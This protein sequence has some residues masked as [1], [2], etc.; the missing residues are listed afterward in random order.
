MTEVNTVL[1]EVEQ[2]R[3]RVRTRAH[4]GAWVP[5]LAIGTFLVCSSLLY[6]QPF[7]RWLVKE[8]QFPYWAGLPDEQRSPVVSYL[9]WFL[10]LPLLVGLIGWWYRW[11]SR[12][13]GIRVAW[14][15]FAIVAIGS[16]VLLGLLSSVPASTI[17]VGSATATVRLNRDLDWLSAFATP[18][19]AM[20]L[21]VVVL[22][23]VER[24]GWLIFAG[25]WIGW[26]TWWQGAF[27]TYGGLGGLPPW[28]GGPGVVTL[29]GV[30]RPGWLL[31]WM[32]LP[33]MVFG[34][35]RGLR[36]RG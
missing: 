14:K 17:E 33:L 6:S 12:R 31:M 28:A 24:S 9:F 10:G 15:W 36:A 26:L 20:A 32:A 16:L 18:L 23:W 35:V 27:L 2:L 5:A 30:D 22:G 29:L 8:I 1:S 21:G 7:S 19:I 25:L 4:G 11:R 3:Q 34:V 13:L